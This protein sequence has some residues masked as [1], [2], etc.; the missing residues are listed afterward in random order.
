MPNHNNPSPGRT[1]SALLAGLFALDGYAATYPLPPPGIDVV[2]DVQVTY[3]RYED[4]F[5]E[6]ARRH[7]MGFDEMVQANPG[8]SAWLPGEGTPVVVPSRFILPKAP[9]EGIVLNVPEMRLYYYPKGQNVVITHPVGI[10]REEWKTPLGKTTVVTKVKDPVWRPPASIR[11]EHAAEG[12]YL[13]E[14]VPAGPDNPL[15]QYALRLGIPGYLIHGTDKPN[16]IGM[17]VTHGCVRLYPE[18][19]ES[20]FRSV[21]VGTPVYLVNQPVKV[22]WNGYSLEMEVHQPLEEDRAQFG[23]LV[24]TAVRLVASTPN[25]TAIPI[26]PALVQTAV[27]QSSGLPVLLTPEQTAMQ[28]PAILPSQSQFTLQ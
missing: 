23:N 24:D 19:I 16:G 20:L 22:G 7:D 14:V 25:P 4:T 3:A 2:G 1:L 10:G 17:R 13:P 28:Q 6:I 21:P 27:E 8:V 15:G 11:A 18:D 9:R 26:D 12:D 5:V